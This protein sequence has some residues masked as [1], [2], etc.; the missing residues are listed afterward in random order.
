MFRF[1]ALLPTLFLLI[2]FIPSEIKPIA[3]TLITLNSS[4]SFGPY[5]AYCSNQSINIEINS[6]TR[7]YTS[8]VTVYAGIS[9][10]NYS[11]SKNYSS[12][13]LAANGTKTQSI[14]L[15]T[16]EYLT[17]NGMY[18]KI[19]VTY[20]VSIDGP[21]KTDTKS[22]VIYPV[23]TNQNI[24]AEDY[25]DSPYTIQ[26]VSYSISLG[27]L[28]SKEESFQ[29]PDYI[30]YFNIDTYHRLNLNSVSFEYKSSG[31]FSYSSAYLQIY[32]ENNCFKYIH[33]NDDGYF[34]IPLKVNM[35]G[36]KGSFTFKNQFYVD[37]ITAQMSFNPEQGFVLT[38]YFYLP[39][40]A[41]EDFVDTNMNVYLYGAGYGSTNI[42]WE[43]E[44]LANQNL[45]GDCSDSDYC[46]IG[47]QKNG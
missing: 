42:T 27:K 43:L 28:S 23:A 41:K 47:E 25:I 10:S 36:N 45:L 20:H 15:P 22:F 8:Y 40:N 6:N 46:I 4:G 24:R 2:E 14:I 3:I 34:L 7:L 19:Q 9:E 39:K 44:Y 16:R 18:I 5:Q 35:D 26:N 29:F 33:K 30:D 32:D 21:D 13:N 17:S 31:P 12:F 1:K 37:P 38:R 11:Y